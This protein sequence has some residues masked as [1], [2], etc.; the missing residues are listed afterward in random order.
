MLQVLMT[1]PGRAYTR[2]ELVE[3]AYDGRHFVSS[4]TV[5][6]HMRRI[7]HKLREA[8]LD[9]IETVHGLGFRLHRG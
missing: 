6:S 4:R 7:R 9:P 3:R 8:G 5:D 2:D 1:S